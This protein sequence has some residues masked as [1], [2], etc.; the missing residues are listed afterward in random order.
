MDMNI[1]SIFCLLISVLII[2]SCEKKEGEDPVD[3]D[4]TAIIDSLQSNPILSTEILKH[5]PEWYRTLP[6]DEGFIYAAGV[7][8]SRR[9][10]I[11]SDKA[12]MK[13][14]MKLAEKLKEMEL[15]SDRDHEK[16]L[17]ADSDPSNGNLSVILQDVIV[18]EKKQFRS[19]K[20]WYSFV[21]LEMKI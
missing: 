13:A 20:L 1:K 19:G 11:A 8:K 21:L 18:K 3:I 7:A 10:K 14:Q 16:P 9:A 6:E 17:G 5:A 12:V 15:Q 2:I 4:S